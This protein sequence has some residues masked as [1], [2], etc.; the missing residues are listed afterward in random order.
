M[1]SFILSLKK[2]D[3][4]LLIL[5][6]M[7]LPS[8]VYGRQNSL[9]IGWS[10]EISSVET[11]PLLELP[12]INVQKLRQKELERKKGIPYRF[13]VSNKVSINPDNNGL[14]EEIN[15]GGHLWRQRI[16]CP[17]ATDLNI[18]FSTYN[19]P[20][21]ARL[22]FYSQ[23]EKYYEGA[24]T[25]RDNKPHG[26][27]WLPLVPGDEA[28]IEVFIPPDSAREE[29]ELELTHVGCGFR[30]MF[31]RQK[32]ES[33]RDQGSCNIDVACSEANAWR[34]QIRSVAR[35]TIQGQFLCTGTLVM[36]AEQKFRNFFLSAYH[37]G[38][39][40]GNASTLV[41]YWNYESPLCGQLNGGSL[42]QNQTGA[43]FR[44]SYMPVDMLLVEL[45]ESPNLNFNVFY[46]GWDRSGSPPQETVGIH[47]PGGCEKSISFNYD[48]LTTTYNCINGTGNNTHWLVNDWEMGTTE[49]GS[50]GSC[51]WD[52]S[53]KRCVGFLSGGDAGCDNIFGSDCYGK[54]SE[55]WEMG[56]NEH[57]RLKDWLDPNNTGVL[58][59]DGSNPP[60]GG[61]TGECGN[62]IIEQGEECD[63]GNTISGDGCSSTCY[64]ETVGGLKTFF[65]K[66]AI[67]KEK[68]TSHKIEIKIKSAENLSKIISNLDTTAL[69]VSLES[70][71]DDSDPILI[72]Q[73]TAE[74]KVFKVTGNRARAAGKNILF[75]LNG[76]RGIIK[77]I[78]KKIFLGEIPSETIK[79]TIDAPHMNQTYEYEDKWNY[80]EKRNGTKIYKIKKVSVRP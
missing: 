42:A 41:F 50:S 31:N 6:V 15:G 10:K 3:I 35:Y 38:V 5:M 28:V 78:H 66:R 20:Q 44:A 75:K 18:G 67:I 29:L 33:M 24:Y 55:A 65:I 4:F 46:S 19:L 53:T 52:A 79:L 22:H 7:I 2:I 45:D 68:R 51:I 14:W 71:P 12:G 62:D 47:H 56:T 26:Q 1:K 59:V 61:D 30:D 17:G 32:N 70:L 69:I 8:L 60:G 13:A 54:F 36:D 49:G 21:G 16:F 64:L 77:F 11:V 25:S 39:N 74:P 48:P 40:T 34:D 9:P 27:L 23:T 76:T 57:E 37:C 63:D 72:Y 58:A 73:L 43:L 80:K